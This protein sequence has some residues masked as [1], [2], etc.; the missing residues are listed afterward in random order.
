M[1]IYL[2]FDSSTQGLTA[3]AIDADAGRVV[4]HHVMSYDD[5]LPEYGTRRGVLPS[6][7]PSVAESSPLMWADA[8]DQMMAI[9]AKSKA[10][11]LAD[12]AAISGAAQ[13]HGSVY[14]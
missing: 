5:G 2:G 14:L 7:D 13:Q 8:L 11:N 10:F 1:P 9:A 4:W 6:T 12:V 3:I